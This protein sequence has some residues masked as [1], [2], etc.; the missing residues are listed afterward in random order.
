MR[1][2]TEIAAAAVKRRGCL[3]CSV[4]W[5]FKSKQTFALFSNN[6][7]CVLVIAEFCTVKNASVNIEKF[8][9]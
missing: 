3:Y 7:V 1:A 4:R 6:K 9:L 2:A 8:H 5:V